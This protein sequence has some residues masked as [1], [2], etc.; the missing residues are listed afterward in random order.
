MYEEV[1]C[2]YRYV[3]MYTKIVRRLYMYIY[4]CVCVSHFNHI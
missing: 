3:C 4:I 1:V 2:I